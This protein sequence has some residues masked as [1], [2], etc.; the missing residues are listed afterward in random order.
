[1]AIL[2]NRPLQHG[3][4]S[5]SSRYH[6]DPTGSR[7]AQRV[8][9][10]STPYGDGVEVPYQRP[11]SPSQIDARSIGQ[12]MHARDNARARRISAA[13]EVDDEVADGEPSTEE[14]YDD[15]SEEQDLSRTKDVKKAKKT[16]TASGNVHR[17]L[18]RINADGELEWRAN[19]RSAGG[20][21]FAI[22]LRL[23]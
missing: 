13:L 5:S 6:R 14:E 22:R 19:V 3:A 10:Y 7:F 9:A 20:K 17:G 23:C 16:T 21:T 11:Y 1:M 15:V 2:A 8:A 18:T 4:Q 12:S